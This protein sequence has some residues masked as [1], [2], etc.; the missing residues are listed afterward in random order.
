M[1]DLKIRRTKSFEFKDST[2]VKRLYKD[3]KRKSV[4]GDK[5]DFE[6]YS[7]FK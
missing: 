4:D 5:K 1:N 2:V 3:E 7:S 6:F